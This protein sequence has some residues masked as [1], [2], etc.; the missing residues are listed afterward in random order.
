M[1]LLKIIIKKDYSSNTMIKIAMLYKNAM[2]FIVKYI[3]L[4]KKDFQ[5]IMK[6]SKIA[7][8]Y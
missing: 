5:R 3:E 6:S 4:H 1:I 8:Q 2:R 7:D